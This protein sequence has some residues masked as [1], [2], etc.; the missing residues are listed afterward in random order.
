MHLMELSV[1]TTLGNLEE[2]DTR[3]KKPPLMG[4]T[5]PLGMSNFG[6]ELLFFS[7]IDPGKNY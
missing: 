4:N 5:K 3:P 2:M 6:V 1:T 7:D